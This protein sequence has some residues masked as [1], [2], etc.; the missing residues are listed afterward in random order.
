MDC[1]GTDDG[2][3]DVVLFNP[4]WLPGDATSWLDRAVYDPD[5]NLLRRFLLQVQ[6]YVKKDGQIYLILSNLGMQLGLF[7]EDDLHKMFDSGNLELVV[8]HDLDNHADSRESEVIS[9]YKLRVK[10]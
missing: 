5:Q 9:L 10:T 1:E 8:K 4:P 3:V 6:H 2:K 7:K